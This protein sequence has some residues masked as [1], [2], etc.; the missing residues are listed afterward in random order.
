MSAAYVC[1]ECGCPVGRYLSFGGV[2]WM[3]EDGSQM[4]AC[5]DARGDRSWI[6]VPVGGA[7]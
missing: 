3:H 1:S 5:N 6:P 4:A 7:A 2:G